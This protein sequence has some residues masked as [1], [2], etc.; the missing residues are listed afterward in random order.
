MGVEAAV[1]A[2][3]GASAI[4]FLLADGEQKR[5]RWVQAMRRGLIR[6]GD[7][8][9]YEQRGICALLRT[10]DLNGSAQER[11]LTRLLHVCADAL[12][13]ED[14]PNI[15]VIFVR[16]SARMQ[17]YGVLSREDREPFEQVMGELGNSGMLEQMRLIDEADERLRQREEMLRREGTQRMRLMRTLGICC[18]A[19]LF[20]ILI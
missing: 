12:E 18:G 16:E 11:S 8:I 20:L 14:S 6:L 1:L 5:I 3:S 13:R 17:E 2:L 4:G 10:V 9:R 15:K 19:G 7:I